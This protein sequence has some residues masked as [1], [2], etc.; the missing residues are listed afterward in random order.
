MSMSSKVPDLKSEV[1]GFE[2]HGGNFFDLF[3]YIIIGI[4][5][6]YQLKIG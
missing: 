4:T 3:F 2:S 5:S 1:R 6:H